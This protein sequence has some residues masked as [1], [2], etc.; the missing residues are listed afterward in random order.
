MKKYEVFMV[1]SD[2][3]AKRVAIDQF[4]QQGRYGQ[5]VAG[6]K[7]PEGIRLVG[8]AIDKPNRELGIERIRRTP[9]LVRLDD[10]VSRT[11]QSNGKAILTCL[12]MKKPSS[13]YTIPKNYHR[14]CVRLI[15]KA[16]WEL[17]LV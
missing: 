1:T 5:G 11:R 4:P 13:A 9:K 15:E 3:K 14:K 7:L 2:A 16:P 6:W 10:A 12:S 17:F 8:I